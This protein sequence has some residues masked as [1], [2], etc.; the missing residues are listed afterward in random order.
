M[1]TT[2]ALLDALKAE[3]KAAGWTYRRLAAELD[4]AEST[5]K[6]MFAGRGDAPLSRI[7]A[8]CERLGIDLSDL[9]RRVLSASPLERELTLQQEQEIVADPKLL[10]VATCCLS[11]WSAEQVLAAY[12]LTRAELVGCL[13]RLDRLGVIE[14]R[15]HERYR[16]RV[17]KT[18]RWR[19]NGPAMAYFREHVAQPYFAG[20]FDG[21][22]EILSVV[23]GSIN[24]A[25]AV[26]FRERL[27]RIASDFAQQHLADQKLDAAHRR[28]YT[29][30]LGARNWWLPAFQAL[31]RTPHPPR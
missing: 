22:A 24:A 14:L 7:D 19:P 29:L 25:V 26:T 9:A 5:I 8:A 4:L 3:L 6:A 31:L 18:F 20:N 11:Q 23:H 10:L 13:A 12:A 27:A 2:R 17:D 16:L 28:P 1:T 30:I 21:E 15:P